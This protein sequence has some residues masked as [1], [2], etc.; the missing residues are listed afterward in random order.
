MKHTVGK[1]L[2]ALALGL[3]LAACGEGSNEA[4]SDNADTAPP[5]TATTTEESTT[6]P[7]EPAATPVT[8][9][10]ADEADGV[11]APDGPFLAACLEVPTYSA[12]DTVSV[13]CV[14]DL[15][16]SPELFAN[17]AGWHVF[18][19]VEAV[20]SE[21][22]YALTCCGEDEEVTFVGLLN[23][24]DLSDAQIDVLCAASGLAEDP[25]SGCGEQAPD[26]AGLADAGWLRVNGLGDFDFGS[27]D[28]TV[29]QA[30]ADVFGPA[31]DQNDLGECG[32]GAMT[33]VT[34][35]DFTLHFQ[36]GEFIG[37]FYRSSDPALTSPS[38]V[39]PGITE[40]ALL[41][42]YDGVNIFADT[43][44]KEFTFEVPA[45]FMGGFFEGDGPEV[46]AMYAGTQCFFR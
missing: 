19:S 3:L 24:N 13:A 30:V 10:P 32:A 21:I 1:L 6:A 14:D 15:A 7:A 37:W 22:D 23:R 44:G 9:D 38:G 46:T 11:A 25:S 36:A 16:V 12:A 43:L 29:Q 8:D 2:L 40:A 42:V 4:A 33:A 34:W 5:T 20:W 17:N 27:S 35:D 39:A 45:G 18:R 28:S 41:D 26:R 31:R